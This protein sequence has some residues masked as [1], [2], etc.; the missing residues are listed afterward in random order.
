MIDYTL[1]TY[2]ILE[3]DG[4]R[5]NDHA[6]MDELQEKLYRHITE[7]KTATPGITTH[8]PRA[9]KHFK[10]P[11][12]VSFE[13]NEL[14]NQTIMKVVAYDRPGLLS[15]IG[16]AMHACDVTLHKAK[17][18]TFGEKAEDIF[19]ITD[20]EGNIVE[21]KQR[22]CLVKTIIEELES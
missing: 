2:L 4:S 7:P 6:R 16:S 19:F 22:E 13:N 17:I 5:F 10:F 11:T 12:Q 8:I 9:A 18:A 3:A 14:Q 20:N 15:Q 1:D 21:N